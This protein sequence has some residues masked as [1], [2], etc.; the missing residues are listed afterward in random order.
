[1]TLERDL[2]YFD[3]NASS[4]LRAEAKA[5]MLV[6]LDVHGNPSSV[7]R[8]GRAA[9][10]ILDQ[11]RA[12]ILKLAGAPTALAVFTSGASE[13]NAMAIHGLI[14]AAKRA[15]NP[16]KHV[17]ASAIE[18]D[19]V[20]AALAALEQEG[21]QIKV[22][23][24]APDRR[25]VVEPW[26]LEAALKENTGPALVS[27]MAANNET[28]VVQPVPAL[29]QVAKA[30]GALFHC[31]AAQ[32]PG[33][34]ALAFDAWGLD[35]MVLSGH[36]LG[37]PKGTGALV[38]RQGL[39]L[40]PLIR[41]GG[42]ELGLRAGTQNVAGLAGFGTAARVAWAELDNASA[43]SRRRAQLEQA[44]L[45]AA[46]GSV[47]HGRE[48]S[49]LP[50]TIC[51]GLAG[52]PAETQVMALDLDGI[53]VSAGSACSSGKVKTS[54]VLSAMGL[55]A[56]TAGEAIRISFGAETTESAFHH[57]IAAYARLATRARARSAA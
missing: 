54:H 22:T 8:E 9:R 1:M 39:A 47:L 15:R 24:I 5:A 18:H 29:A 20:L 3:W 42:Q 21:A 41:G 46:P 12:D 17:V 34:I 45:Q 13:A 14:G 57:L 33:R 32:A 56:K 23:L 6:A 25:G 19:S 53:S 2:F 16:V 44:L 30:Q 36:K 50:Q 11:A 28:G 43:L 52:L 37:G 10:V 26:A 38:L 40:E 27:I 35:S 55:D 49:R 4:P 51:I 31:D 48:A 7:H